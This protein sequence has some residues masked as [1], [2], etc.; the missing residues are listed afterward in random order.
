MS[1]SNAS[2]EPGIIS[3][4]ADRLAAFYLEALGFHLHRELSFPAGEVRRLVRGAAQLKIYQPAEPNG[5]PAR[6]AEWHR[7]A[8]WAYAAL[9]VDDAAAEVAAVREHGG[10]VITDVTNHRPGA[11]FALVADPEGNVWEI[12]QEDGP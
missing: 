5:P 9:H 7:R 2:I 3:D 4:D 12:L 10:S 6:P 8:G 11:H 1:P